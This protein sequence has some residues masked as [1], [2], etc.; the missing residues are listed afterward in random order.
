MQFNVENQKMIDWL[1]YNLRACGYTVYKSRNRKASLE[2]ERNGES[3]GSLNKDGELALL[4]QYVDERGKIEGVMSF[5]A[6]YS[7]IPLSTFMGQRD[8]FCVDDTILSVDLNEETG[9]PRFYVYNS[10]QNILTYEEMVEKFSYDSLDDAKA[11]HARQV[12]ASSKKNIRANAENM[13]S[14]KMTGETIKEYN[15]NSLSTFGPIRK[16]ECWHFNFGLAIVNYSDKVFTIYFNDG[17]DSQN[18]ISRPYELS[19]VSEIDGYRLSNYHGSKKT[20]EVLRQNELKPIGE[21]YKLE[22]HSPNL[23]A[24]DNAI[25]KHFHDQI[26]ANEEHEDGEDE[27][28]P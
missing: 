2:I 27:Y 16:G 13:G 6:E 12:N 9:Q 24:F 23:W 3:I 17:V 22:F 15:C 5:T 7:K 28:E 1:T 11:E 26:S 19:Y 4:E 20:P 8:L 21:I 25:I 18:I 14:K 10:F